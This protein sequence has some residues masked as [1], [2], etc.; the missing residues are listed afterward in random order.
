MLRIRLAALC[1]FSLLTTSCGKPKEIGYDKLGYDN[2]IFTDPET[3]Q[4]FTGIARD[5]H[6]KNGGLKSEYPMK[7]GKLHG[8]VKE[9]FPDGKPLSEIEYRNGEHHGLCKEWTA[10][11]KPFCER[12]Y[13]NDHLVS[14]KKL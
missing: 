5:Y 6:K 1:A 8:M 11:G 13:E 12:V 14:E 9:W 3:K 10:D 2:G 7:D 4:G